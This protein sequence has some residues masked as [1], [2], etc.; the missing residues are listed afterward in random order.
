MPRYLL[1]VSFTRG[2]VETPMEEWKPEEITAH[3]DGAVGKGAVGEY[4]L[5]AAIAALH[6]Q[7][8]TADD[9]DWRQ[10]LALY[11]LLEQL[12]R[13]TGRNPQ[14]GRRSRHGQR[15]DRRIG[16]ARHGRRASGRPL[17]PRGGPRTPVGDG[18]RDGGC[19]GALSRRGQSDDERSGK[20]LPGYVVGAPQGGSCEGSIARACF[21]QVAKNFGSMSIVSQRC[22]RPQSKAL[23]PHEDGK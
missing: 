12:T 21:S 22:I 17:P 2:A 8:H 7:A 5:Q 10:I 11:G 16:P 6:D 1:G 3:L 4:R 15:P 23:P 20:A 19:A 13:K 14:Q 9:T 18:R